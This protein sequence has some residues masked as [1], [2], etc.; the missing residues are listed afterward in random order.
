[1]EA[2]N[3]DQVFNKKFSSIKFNVHL[4]A[5]TIH[6]LTVETV[7]H[8]LQELSQWRNWEYVQNVQQTV[9]NVEQSLHA[10]NV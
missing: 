10:N 4:Y 8:A 2:A 1:M 7:L 5:P 3:V 9:S 6:T